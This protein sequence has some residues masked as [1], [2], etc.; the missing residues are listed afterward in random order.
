MQP[1]L[2]SAGVQRHARKLVLVGHGVGNDIDVLRNYVGLDMVERY[3]LDTMQDTSVVHQYQFN[4][5]QG[6]SLKNVCANLGMMPQNLHNAGND[7][8]Y[9]LDALFRLAFHQ[10]ELY[11]PEDLW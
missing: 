9:T 5:Q 7:A 10:S 6:A 3:K 1:Y 8:Y 11:D 4:R 2:K